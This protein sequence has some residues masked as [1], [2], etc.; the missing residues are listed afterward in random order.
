MSLMLTVT[1]YVSPRAAISAGKVVVGTQTVT[2]SAPALAALPEGLRNELALA[3]EANETLG[4]DAAE[5]PIVEPTLA[6]LEPVLAHRAARR[7]ATDEARRIA[8]ARAA[9]I[10]ANEARSSSAKDAARAKALRAWV[11]THGDDDQRARMAEGYLQEREILEEVCA[12]LL[13]LPGFQDYD[14]LRRGDACEC[15]CAGG[16][17]FVEA[18]PKYVDARQYARLQEA[19]EAAP[20]EATVTLIEH[21]AQCPHCNCVPLTRFEARVTMPWHG[22]ALVRSYALL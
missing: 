16:V 21:I 14:A 9:E 5:P 8:E 15:A 7:R 20:A 4:K 18:P 1:V 11:E 22:W 12:E 13:E 2:I 19:R 3:Y 17:T 6:A 10:A